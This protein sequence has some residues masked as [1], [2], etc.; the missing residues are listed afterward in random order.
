MVDADFDDD[1]QV[2]GADLARLLSNWGSTSG[3]YDLVIN[4]VIDGADLTRLLSEW[5]S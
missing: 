2:G 4:G 1:G 5:S 3:E